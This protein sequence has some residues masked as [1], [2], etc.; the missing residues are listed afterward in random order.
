M[1]KTDNNAPKIQI[2]DRLGGFKQISLDSNRPSIADES[3]F[4][5][6]NAIATP[7]RGLFS[8]ALLWPLAVGVPTR[9]IYSAISFG[10]VAPAAGF[11]IIAFFLIPLIL[12]VC[13][14][15]SQLPDTHGMFCLYR[16][17]QIALGL[18]LAI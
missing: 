12:V 15:A 14:T 17:L 18:A 3:L 5:F 13:Y 8:D 7:S 11:G 10:I 4:R 2:G 6:A 9:L 16:L 1:A